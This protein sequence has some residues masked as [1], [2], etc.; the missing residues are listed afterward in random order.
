MRHQCHESSK[1]GKGFQ[2][3]HATGNYIIFQQHFR[4]TY[5]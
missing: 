4:P 2:E 5:C 1:L 3:K